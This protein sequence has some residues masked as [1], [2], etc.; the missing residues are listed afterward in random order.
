[1]GLV[2]E[3][4]DFRV[5]EGGMAG[6]DAEIDALLTK[7]AGLGDIEFGDVGDLTCFCG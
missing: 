6:L 4:G 7:G 5:S 1:M 2:A 3:A